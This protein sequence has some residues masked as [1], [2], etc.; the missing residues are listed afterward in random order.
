[1]NG[2]STALRNAAPKFCAGQA[3][4]IAQDPQQRHLIGSVDVPEFAVNLQIDHAV[5]RS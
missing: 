1:M 5:P 2:A 3:E 4:Q